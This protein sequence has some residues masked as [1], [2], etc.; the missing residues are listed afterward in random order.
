MVRS[1]EELKKDK[2]EKDH[3]LSTLHCVSRSSTFYAAITNHS[4]NTIARRPLEQIL[5]FSFMWTEKEL[6][7]NFYATKSEV[8]KFK[9]L[10]LYFNYL[11]L[12]G[13]AS[14]GFSRITK[15]NIEEFKSHPR[16][17]INIDRR[18]KE[19]LDHYLNSPASDISEKLSLSSCDNFSS[20]DDSTSC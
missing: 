19:D 20:K 16:H 3:A 1:A 13:K 12:K 18:Y 8:R 6:I 7:G 2:K 10:A 14:L 17:W 15:E 5:L 11:Q 4:V 9:T